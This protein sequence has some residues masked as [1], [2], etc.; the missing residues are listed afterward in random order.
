MGDSI[1]K[2]GNHNHPLVFT[3]KHTNPLTGVKEIYPIPDGSAALIK[4]TIDADPAL[5][6]DQAAT[7][8]N[9]VNYPGKVQYL[10]QGAFTDLVNTYDVEIKLTLPDGTIRKFPGN[11]EETFSTL[12][13]LQSKGGG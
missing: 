10:L 6:I 9:Q 2:Q 3:L 13:V 4:I 7:I 12:R 5:L 8:L 1:V 11:E